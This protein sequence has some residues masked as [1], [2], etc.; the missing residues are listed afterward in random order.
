MRSS[1]CSPLFFCEDRF[2]KRSL[3]GRGEGRLTLGVKVHFSIYLDV[4]SCFS[5]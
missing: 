4:N 1:D 5:F 2:M 3:R